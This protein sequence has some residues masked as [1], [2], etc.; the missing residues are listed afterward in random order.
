MKNPTYENIVTAT[1]INAPQIDSDVERDIESIH[2]MIHAYTELQSDN[3]TIEESKVLITNNMH[4]LTVIKQH[5]SKLEK[6]NV[7]LTKFKDNEQPLRDAYSNQKIKLDKIN[8]SLIK[9]KY[10]DSDFK[11]TIKIILN[12]VD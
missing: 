9:Y 12:E 2:H 6:E 8:K 1:I 4:P 11:D 5:I 7:E 3:L 10:D